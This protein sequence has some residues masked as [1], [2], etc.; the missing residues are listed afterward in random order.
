MNLKVRRAVVVTLLLGLLAPL[1]VSAGGKPPVPPPFDLLIVT[2]KLRDGS[3]ALEFRVSVTDTA[4]GE[5]VFAPKLVT[6]PN[7]IA[8]ASQAGPG[9]LQFTF[10]I[11]V[12]A[13]GTQADYQFAA[14]RGKDVL[15]E[16]CATIPVK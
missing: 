10:S 16:T 5:V 7:R 2:N 9:G 6:K 14:R 15:Q 13:E 8:D 12:N 4:T 11:A 1:L 3:G